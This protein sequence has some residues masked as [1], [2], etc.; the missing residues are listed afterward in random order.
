MRGK[1]PPPGRPRIQFPHSKW[2]ANMFEAFVG[3]VDRMEAEDRVKE[4]F[5]SLWYYFIKLMMMYNVV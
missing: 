3:E 1:P 2:R 4:L 5:D